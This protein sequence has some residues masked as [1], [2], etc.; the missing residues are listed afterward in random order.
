MISFMCEE[1]CISIL[2]A[3]NGKHLTGCEHYPV[4][5]RGKA[6]PEK[7]P[8]SSSPEKEKQKSGIDYKNTYRTKR[9][10]KIVRVRRNK[11][12]PRSGE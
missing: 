11:P 3:E 1:C 12:K 8:R 6:V 9:F 7:A 4:G 2:K 10:G 5:K